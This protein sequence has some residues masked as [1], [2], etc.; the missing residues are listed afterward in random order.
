MSEQSGSG[1]KYREIYPSLQGFDLSA[2]EFDMP[3][4][5]Y[6]FLKRNGI[7]N[8]QLLLEMSDDGLM[9]ILVHKEKRDMLLRRN[10]IIIEVI[11]E[12]LREWSDSQD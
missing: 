7:H 9:D 1:T 11:N 8:V 2:E 10:S 6:N 3:I 4:H 12:K 5:V